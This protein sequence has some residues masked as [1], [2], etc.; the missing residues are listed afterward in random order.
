MPF[1]QA[2]AFL[3]LGSKYEI[4]QLRFE[5][6][7]R[8]VTECPS[9]PD[10][11]DI[12]LENE[13]HEIAHQPAICH[14][15]FN[16]ARETGHLLLL[17]AVFLVLAE[18]QNCLE[19]FIDGKEREDGSIALLSPEDQR[20]CTLGIAKLR[21][22]QHEEMSKWLCTT[23]NSLFPNCEYNLQCISQ[24]RANFCNIFQSGSQILPLV[25]WSDTDELGLCGP[26]IAVSKILYRDGLLSI[27]NELPS[28]LG[29]PEWDELLKT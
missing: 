25:G 26:C 23:D 15:I 4:A 3:R 1:A 14:D 19:L 6:L 9:N 20:L 2:A 18:R 7:R 13:W 24:R 8:F 16:L 22:R 10:G 28:M 11:W 21:R 17:P 5:A 27:W 12:A 29:L